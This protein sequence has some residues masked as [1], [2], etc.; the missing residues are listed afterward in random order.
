M[1]GDIEVNTYLCSLAVS[2]GRV[3]EALEVAGFGLQ[4]GTGKADLW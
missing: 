1:N 3:E 2:I 4:E